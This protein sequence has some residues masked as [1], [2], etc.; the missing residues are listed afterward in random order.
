MLKELSEL[1]VESYR[2]LKKL[3]SAVPAKTKARQRC[4]IQR[5]VAELRM[6]RF[7][8]AQQQRLVAGLKD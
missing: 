2:E 6:A 4:K 7:Q 5:H 8:K 1:T 3:W